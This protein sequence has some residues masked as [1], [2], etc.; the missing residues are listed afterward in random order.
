VT[1]TGGDRSLSRAGGASLRVD[2][3]AGKSLA[4]GVLG[5]P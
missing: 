3:Q 4:C 1:L 5:G 2:D